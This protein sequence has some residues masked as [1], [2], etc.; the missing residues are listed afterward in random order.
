MIIKHSC[1][2]EVNVRTWDVP[3]VRRSF[4]NLPCYECDQLAKRL[5]EAQLK[6]LAPL[7]NRVK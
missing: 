1:G 5:Q 7:Q 4:S 3:F 2:H 6:E